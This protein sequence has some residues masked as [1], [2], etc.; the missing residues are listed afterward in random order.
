MPVFDIIY[1]REFKIEVFIGVYA[2]EQRIKQP[3]IFDIE[4]GFDIC[5][6]AYSESI[7]DTIDY[8]EVTKKITQWVTHKHFVLLETLVEEVANLLLREYKI[9]SVKLRVNKLA[10]V[11]NVKEVGIVIERTASA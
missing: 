6:A 4:L 2:W 8:A 5:K 1:L 10:A 9:K 11:P 3:I 7:A